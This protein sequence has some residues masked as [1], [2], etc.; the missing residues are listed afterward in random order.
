MP[1]FKA[2]DRV[3]VIH[4]DR[5]WD[6]WI[7]ELERYLGK[8]GIIQQVNG[9]HSAYVHFD[10]GISWWYPQSGLM[11]EEDDLV[12]GDKVKAVGVL[13]DNLRM[14]GARTT[15]R[16]LIDEGVLLEVQDENVRPDYDEPPY[17][18][19]FVRVKVLE[20]DKKGLQFHFYRYHLEKVVADFKVGDIVY[21]PEVP[22]NKD[23]A[24]VFVRGME[25]LIGKPLVIKRILAGLINAQ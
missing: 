11:H 19:R 3:K 12:K 4:V 21:V 13:P 20:G 6:H 9:Q 14:G 10:D 15:K 24:P 18:R 22:K 2:G 1:K 16:R 17:E 23:E 25:E 8:W 5:E 7:D